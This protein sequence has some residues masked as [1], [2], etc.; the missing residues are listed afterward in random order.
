MSPL[1]LMSQSSQKR[2]VTHWVQEAKWTS[3]P[4]QPVETDERK[5]R[6]P[7]EMKSLDRWAS[8]KPLPHFSSLYTE[9][10]S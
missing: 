5:R 9:T 10:E 4:A 2:Q 3:Q 7:Q 1:S 8:N 6:H